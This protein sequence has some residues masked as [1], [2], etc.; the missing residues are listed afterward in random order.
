MSIFKG[1]HGASSRLQL[2]RVPQ[3]RP[4]RHIIFIVAFALSASPAGTSEARDGIHTSLTTATASDGGAC[5]VDA[6][7]CTTRAPR[8]TSRAGSTDKDGCRHSRVL[9]HEGRRRP[10]VSRLAA[11]HVASPMPAGTSR[12]TPSGSSP[13]A[14]RA[15]AR[16][17]IMRSRMT[18]RSPPV[19]WNQHVHQ[20][21][22]NAAESDYT[23]MANW[24]AGVH[25]ALH[26]DQRLRHE[27]DRRRQ[28]HRGHPPQTEHE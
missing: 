22:M 23:I 24:F 26:A 10:H 21:L 20:A 12:S 7:L 19:N 25:A 5:P 17:R 27:A 13:P 2:A 8:S 6:Q 1:H 11:G 18:A 3:R 16:R 14:S 28:Q 9:E 15:A 4:A